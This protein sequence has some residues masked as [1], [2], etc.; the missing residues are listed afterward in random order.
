M[1]LPSSC[2]ALDVSSG[3]TIPAFRRR[4]TTLM[5]IFASKKETELQALEEIQDC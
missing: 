4:V 1:C 2:Q 3:S 5:N